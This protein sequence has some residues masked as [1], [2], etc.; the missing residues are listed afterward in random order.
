[1]NL[2]DPVDDHTASSSFTDLQPSAPSQT[3][4]DQDQVSGQFLTIEMAQVGPRQEERE[5]TNI[6]EDSSN[7]ANERSKENVLGAEQPKRS[8]SLSK[9]LARVRESIVGVNSQFECPVCFEEMKP[10]V[11]MFQCRQGHVVCQAY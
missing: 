10:P 5:S 2:E 3:T 4:D 9:A 8:P 6:S 11:H 7:D 1:M